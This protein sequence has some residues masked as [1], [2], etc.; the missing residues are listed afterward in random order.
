MH[1]F[2]D[3]VVTQTNDVE[4]QLFKVEEQKGA[5]PFHKVFN[6]TRDLLA[7][8]LRAKYGERYA[9]AAGLRIT[10]WLLVV[11]HCAARRCRPCWPAQTC[12]INPRRL[13]LFLLGKISLPSRLP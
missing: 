1:R 3:T 5:I 9:N 4:V 8:Q 12:W 10:L 6:M 2:L 11:H 13:M 7:S